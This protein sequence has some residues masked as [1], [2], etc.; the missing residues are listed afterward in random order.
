MQNNNQTQQAT[1]GSTT[2]AEMLSKLND[3]EDALKDLQEA[4]IEKM[5]FF[6]L[7]GMGI[8]EEHHSTFLANMLDINATHGLNNKVLQRFC[9]KL[10]DYE[11]A[12]DGKPK[13]AL[14]QNK[15]ILAAVNIS[16]ADLDA[17]ANSDDVITKKEFQIES[18]LSDTKDSRLDIFMYSE[19][20]KTVLVIENKVGSTTHT[21]QLKRYESALNK[22][23]NNFSNYDKRI[24][25]Y[26]SP[27]GELPYNK[28]G[29]EQ[30]NEHWCVMDYA[31][32]KTIIGEVIKY[33]LKT[34]NQGKTKLK[35]I[36]E[37]YIDY[38][39]TNILNSDKNIQK[40][41][42]DL[43]SKHHDALTYLTT[44]VDNSQESLHICCDELKHLRPDVHIVDGSQNVITDLG[45]KKS[46][47]FYTDEMEKVFT[48]NGND[49]YFILKLYGIIY[50]NQGNISIFVEGRTMDNEDDNWSPVQ[51]DLIDGFK[52]KPGKKYFKPYKSTVSI[53][54][55]SERYNEIATIESTMRA[56]IGEFV[57]KFNKF[58]PKL[59]TINP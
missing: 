23:I 12:D 46:I 42:S 36:L 57:D 40:L 51:R 39:D 8:K 47:F 27:F 41:C 21:D 56:K 20:T 26:L 18:N 30:Y 17:F 22:P 14:L 29:D 55:A 31:T 25:V 13:P 35:T 32:I 11:T 2:V 53:S 10:W 44:H 9:K 6:D 54:A 1:T 28:D 19:K 34:L 33:D 59:K 15:N 45:N 4:K 38:M 48:R 16:E 37:D 50:N 5:N 43:W 3:L 24:F 52:V 58:E 49:T 7:S